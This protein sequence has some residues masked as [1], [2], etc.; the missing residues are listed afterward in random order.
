MAVFKVRRLGAGEGIILALLDGTNLSTG[1][2][3]RQRDVTRKAGASSGRD[4][5]MLC[6]W[7]WRGS[8]G[9]QAEECRWLLEA[10]KG[11]ETVSLRA[12]K[13]TTALFTLSF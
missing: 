6:W 3:V 9:T 11:Q 8:K 5:K 12:S 13:R 4:W 7:L 10:G 2:A 1:V